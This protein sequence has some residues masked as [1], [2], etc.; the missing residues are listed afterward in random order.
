[1]DLKQNKIT[2]LVQPLLQR[3]QLTGSQPLGHRMIRG[4]VCEAPCT[5]GLVI[6]ACGRDYYS[7]NTLGVN[8]AGYIK[9]VIMLK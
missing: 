5:A 7:Q 6:A 4:L 2:N 9:L 8:P 3:A 1:M